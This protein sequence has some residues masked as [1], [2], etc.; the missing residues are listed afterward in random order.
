MPEC[1]LR[2]STTTIMFS[3]VIAGLLTFAE[4][5][6]AQEL[7]GTVRDSATGA[8]IRGAVVMLLD[9]NRESVVRMLTSSSG[10]FRLPHR[11][12]A[13]LRVI[14]IGF[15]PYEISL[16]RIVGGSELTIIMT[17]F[18][19]RLPPVAVNTSAVCPRRNDQAEA[20]AHWSAATDGL[21][22]LLVAADSSAQ[23]GTVTQLLFD[24]LLDTG[25]RRVVRQKV[26]IVRT[27]IA[28]P[29]RADRS[30]GEFVRVGYV[31]RTADRSTYYGPDPAV[32]LDSSFA[33]THC[34]SMRV[35]RRGHPDEVGVA[36]TPA[37]GRDSI[38]DIAGVLWMDRSPLALKSLE[39]EYRNV[40]PI[41]IDARS[42]GRLDFETLAN[43]VPVI[44][45]WHVRSPRLAYRPV[46]QIRGL[47]ALRTGIPMIL[48]RH[49]TGGLIASGILADGTAWSAPLATLAGRVMNSHT[50]EPVPNARVALD[51]TD[52]AT[53]SDSAG[54]FAFEGVLPG[55]YVARVRD[56]VAILEPIPDS[57][58]ALRS[59]SLVQQVVTRIATLQVDAGLG[60][61]TPFDV[62]LP[63]RAPVGGCAGIQESEPRFIMMGS[64]VTPDSV[65]LATAKVRMA[66]ADTA[67]GTTAETIIDA[68]TDAGGRFVIC[69]I[70][71]G[72]KLA[73]RVM[74]PGGAMYHGWSSVTAVDYDELGR[75]RNSRLRKVT[76]I[77]ARDDPGT[78]R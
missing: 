54:Q 36:F 50:G 10:S 3:L 71:A 48:A 68:M 46:R 35:D 24:K 74:L 57:T 9:A 55:P 33:A 29:I 30:P 43:G 49:E 44:R 45:Y 75:M 14:R 16:A 13:T 25:G 26:Q 62:A 51:S 11:D 52:Y 66:W 4:P 70:P 5:A 73:A 64:V 61:V 60:S 41:V 39:F 17:R 56:S 7:T 76:L 18:G 15:L 32:L 47:P 69:G 27:G 31:Q 40:D 58:G 20:L 8:P 19:S 77:V 42:G 38:S 28:V 23:P 53:S 22:A 2:D 78:F 59:D 1:R 34:L 72:R 63:W 6:P 67:R 21:Y 65:A 37:R 12:A